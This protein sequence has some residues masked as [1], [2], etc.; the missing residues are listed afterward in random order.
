METEKVEARN[1]SMYRS[2]WIKVERLAKAIAQL[3]GSKENA[4][5]AM[6]RIVDEYREPQICPTP[7]AIEEV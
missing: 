1:I 3:T 5:A 7:V 6:R 2:Q 4:S